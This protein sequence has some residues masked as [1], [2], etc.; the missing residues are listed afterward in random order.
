MLHLAHNAGLQAD[1]IARK[2]EIDHLAVAV[3]Q[4]LVTQPHAAQR[5]IKLWAVRPFHQQGCAGIYLKL[6]HLE[7]LHKPD[8]IFREVNEHITAL[9]WTVRALRRH[10]S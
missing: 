8:F 5:S 6:T 1:K 2:D 7:L 10:N 3:F 9:Q 4:C